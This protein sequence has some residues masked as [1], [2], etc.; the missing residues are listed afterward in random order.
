MKTINKIS[1]LVVNNNLKVFLTKTYLTTLEKYMIKPL[2]FPDF[3]LSCKS[4]FF[5]GAKTVELRLG[6]AGV[7]CGL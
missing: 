6:G 4:V 1:I 3:L 2:Y 5:D 7:G